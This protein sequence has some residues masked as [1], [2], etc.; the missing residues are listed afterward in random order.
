MGREAMRHRERRAVHAKI[1]NGTQ[2]RRA[3]TEE[4][5]ATLFRSIDHRDVNATGVRS[6]APLDLDGLYPMPPIHLRA[7]SGNVGFERLVTILSY[8]AWRRRHGMVKQLLIAG[9][10]PT[11][12]VSGSADLSAAEDCKLR[13]MLTNRNGDGLAAAA[14]VYAVEQIVKLR[15]FAARDALLLGGRSALP[16]CV[17]C[18]A[19]HGATVCFDPC[20]CACCETC[21]WRSLLEDPS[22]RGEL[23]CPS[24]GTRPPLRGVKE[25]PTPL[26][27][28]AS[29]SRLG[30]DS[31]SIT[32]L[33]ASAAAAI[34][35]TDWRCECCAYTNFGSRPICRHCAAPRA[36][37]TR[38]P[39]P[40]FCPD[41]R[42][43]VAIALAE[44]EGAVADG[45]LQ[46][47]DAGPSGLSAA[48]LPESQT[49]WSE[50]DGE[51]GGGGGQH[52]AEAKGESKRED[53]AASCMEERTW[54][55]V[56]VEMR[57]ERRRALGRSLTFLVGVATGDG[58]PLLSMIDGAI[59]DATGKSADAAEPR[60][61]SPQPTS[62]Q[63][64]LESTNLG[65]DDEARLAMYYASRYDRVR[66]IGILR[67]IIVDGKLGWE[68]HGQS[69][70]LL[71]PM[72]RA[73]PP[74]AA[75]KVTGSGGVFVGGN[76]DFMASDASAASAAS[77]ASDA[78]AVYSRSKARF[79]ALPPREAEL[80]MVK[81]L[82][83]PQ[84]REAAAAAAAAGD[85]FKIEALET[86][87]FPLSASL[88]EYGQSAVFLAA[89][90][91]H[92]SL[93]RKL[94]S[95]GHAVDAP[96]HGGAT[97]ASAAAARGHGEALD[98]LCQAGAAM[99]TAG[100]AGLT[101]LQ[102]VMRRAMAEG[103][104]LLQ[105][106]ARSSADRAPP[107]TVLP[108]PLPLPLPLPGAR[109][110]RLINPIAKHAG[111]GACCIDGGVPEAVLSRLDALFAA[112]PV[113]A[114]VKCSQGLSDR[115]YYNDAEGWVVDA[116]RAAVH[117]VSGSVG[118]SGGSAP[119]EGEAMTQ[120]RFLRYAEA[121]GGLPPHVDLSRTRRDG[122]TSRCTFILYLTDCA[123]GG[124][125]VLL[126]RLA[127]PSHVHA[128]VTPARGRLLIFPH[129]CP[130]LAREV[131]AE[132][133]PKL[134]LRGEMI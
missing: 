80:H 3:P 119:C 113:A 69:V 68:V 77:D 73:A 76:D 115:S 84:R 49:G 79:R 48:S 120:M 125:T 5:A 8:A 46:P 101:P 59:E 51:A 111:A 2:E 47:A 108:P 14:A 18:G 31:S 34:A 93:L 15:A 35:F 109:L 133:L 116:L 127:Q 89:A 71:R 86:L 67:S 123:H 129:L 87:G 56:N 63:F 75:P 92:A 29:A 11:L 100:P 19:N 7:G 38:P 91:G 42:A 20:G 55:V 74:T 28:N 97:P 95:L 45:G 21:V 39:P 131:V 126:E 107:Q 52:Q 27:S 30:W 105:F 57:V 10:S 53:A 41:V 72:A 44:R 112:L 33:S 37:E 25:D 88:D 6:L 12:S 128:A 50:A 40:S 78:S 70:L 62:V 104:G 60:L 96:S 130:H 43:A 61:P 36:P 134:L 24:C 13:D 122:R 23:S 117:S 22:A 90:N 16:P 103:A 65:S 98:V 1:K 17:K 81:I 58:A 132:G 4:E 82:T 102:Y 99:E 110:V 54:C 94:L 26:E 124:E 121:G 66:G 9:A 83:E 64:V 114:R 32:S 106:A 118:G 85:T